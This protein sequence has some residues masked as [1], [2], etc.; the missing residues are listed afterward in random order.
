M[1]IRVWP[2]RLPAGFHASLGAQIMDP[3]ERE[4]ILK[5]SRGVAV[6]L[7]SIYFAYLYFTRES[8]AALY[9]FFGC[10]ADAT[11]TFQSPR[12]STSSRAILRRKNRS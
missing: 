1:L 9:I 4:D 8:C 11:C 3:L 12:T 5:V 7:L 6:I 2:C 10:V